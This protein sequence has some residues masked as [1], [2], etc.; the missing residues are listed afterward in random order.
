MD[1]AKLEA[2]VKAGG[3]RI[4]ATPESLV[5]AVERIQVRGYKPVGVYLVWA[6]AAMA[7]LQI[8]LRLL[9]RL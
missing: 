3:G 9:G 7:A 2:I 6:A 5:E 1:R 8:V 4:H